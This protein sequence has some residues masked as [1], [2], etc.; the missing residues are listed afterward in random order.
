MS[1]SIPTLKAMVKAGLTAEQIV[2]AIEEDY[3]ARAGER[4]ADAAR[5]KAER[6]ASRMSA[7]HSRTS[8]D[9]A[10]TGQVI[11]LAARAATTPR[12]QQ[13][14]DQKGAA[15]Q[16]SIEKPTTLSFLDS[17]SENKKV[18]SRIARAR[19]SPKIPLPD[20][21]QPAGGVSDCDRSELERF[22]QSA[23]AHDRRYANW[24]AAWENWKTSPYRGKGHGQH[25]NGGNA[26]AGI[27][28]TELA[29][30]LG[31]AGSS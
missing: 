21:W 13:T 22:K 26:G 15:E 16:A 9:I 29:D 18:R 28:F 10:D 14:E 6:A 7:G 24:N 12:G 17:G 19:A 27:G 25:R 3:L 8:Q 30:L 11:D 23:L 4:A 2:S 20:D 5:K 31:R 1:I